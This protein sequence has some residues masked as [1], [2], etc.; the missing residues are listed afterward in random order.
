MIGSVKKSG[1]SAVELT[2]A[3]AVAGVLFAIAIPTFGALKM[4][5]EFA[6]GEQ[7]VQRLLT[8]ARWSAINSGRLETR[9]H[10]EGNLLRVR[11]G[12]N[13]DSPVVTTL[14]VTD[15]N[16]TISA[17]DLPIRFDP[18]GA[19]RN[20]TQPTVTIQNSRISEVT[21]F[22]IDVLGRIVTS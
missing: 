17:T 21:T 13:A 7:A 9:V 18:R 4:Q 11:A 16:A 20:S 19:R 15:Y 14:D 6:S 1:F 12:S 8:R 2:V 3:I 10:L 22:A 5:V